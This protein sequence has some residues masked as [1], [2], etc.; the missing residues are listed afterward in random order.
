MEMSQAVL[1]EMNNDM[2][3]INMNESIVTFDG[4][5]NATQNN[6]YQSQDQTSQ[7]P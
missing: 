6:A 7:S 1:S 5:N 2:S 3:K 4:N